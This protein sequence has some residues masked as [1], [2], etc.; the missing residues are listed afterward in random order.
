MSKKIRSKRKKLS[1][2][3]KKKRREETKFKQD[4]KTVFTNSSFIQIPTRHVHF[5]FVGRTGEL[6][7]VFLFENI[8]IL[9]EDTTLKDNDDLKG[10]LL[11]TD[12][13]FEHIRNHSIEFINL[14][15]TKFPEFNEKKSLKYSD[16]DYKLFFL[17]CSRN[18]IDKTYEERH[19]KIKF[20]DYPYLQYFLN[21]SKTISRTTR[22]ELFKFLGLNLK[23][24]GLQKSGDDKCTYSGF[25]LP[26]S[27]SGFPKGYKVVSFLIEPSRLLEQSYVLRKDSWRDKDCLY[28]RLLIKRKINSMR[29]YLTDENRVFIN[30]II[31]TLPSNTE[32]FDM[33]GNQLK[34]SQIYQMQLINIQLDKELNTIG[35]IDGQHRV[36]TY[37]EGMDRAEKHISILRD[38][39][40]LLLTGIIYPEN[41][42]DLEKTKFEAKLFLEINDK[43]ARA[44]GDL[45][46]AIETLVDP[47]SPTAIAKKIIINLG[48]TGHLTNLLEEHFYDVGKIKTTSI[49]SYGMKHIV[50]LSGNDSLFS[51]WLNPDKEKL[52]EQM[53]IKL[54]D[55]YIDFCTK[56]I[57]NFIS[58][59]RMNIPKEIWTPDKKTSRV[60]TTTTINGLI[61]CLRKVIE[62]KKTGDIDYYKEKFSSL[63]L[64]F[65]PEKFGYKSS[66]WKGLGEEIY[67]QCFS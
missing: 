63:E 16:V 25:L 4:I 50:K 18:R 35:I 19:P 15:Q 26:E 9:C 2:E 29:A 30:N 1:P 44:K 58:G 27:P 28:Q 14:L 42:T 49:V 61:F 22:F 55:S 48:Q 3:E 37:Y 20:L 10:H 57:N 34:V 38:K 43:Q 39:Q 51:I 6:D 8:L 13:F 64:D 33:D 21:L 23:E 59:F 56:E 11:K 65:T 24:I 54:L 40:H 47:F 67:S 31:V 60:L 7:N 41:I 52:L 53:D 36:F 32:I 62:N 46:Q 66:H 45:K 17:Y 12:D 5:E